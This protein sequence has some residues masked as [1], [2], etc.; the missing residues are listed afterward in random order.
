MTEERERRFMMMLRRALL[1]IVK[2]IEKE[3]K[4]TAES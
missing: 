1:T 3:Y 2:W 4:L